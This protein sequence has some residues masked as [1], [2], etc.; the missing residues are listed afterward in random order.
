MSVFDSSFPTNYTELL[1]KLSEIHS[2]FT[3]GSLQG[4]EGWEGVLFVVH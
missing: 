1:N 4:E 2:W 3:G